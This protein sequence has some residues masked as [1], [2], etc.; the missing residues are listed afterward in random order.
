[1]SIVGK[2]RREIAWVLFFGVRYF[3]NAE[4]KRDPKP[5]YGEQESPMNHAFF[6]KFTALAALAL[7]IGCIKKDSGFCPEPN[8]DIQWV[9][10]T[11]SNG[12]WTQ[13]KCILCDASVAPEDYGTWANENAAEDTATHSISNEN[14]TPC[15]YV[16]PG[17]QRDW[18]TKAECIDAICTEEPNT[19]D[20][21][22]K[23]HGAWRVIK[24]ILGIPSSNMSEGTHQYMMIGTLKT[25]T[26][27]D[28]IRVEEKQV[29]SLVQ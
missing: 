20:G 19:N 6:F 16:Y 1:M 17:T 24:D 18:E 21:V 4:A 29:S 28:Q 15:L 14:A 11:E 23:N 22:H 13:T 27:F 10:Y 12:L 8:D 2:P 5:I 3:L 9:H 26:D 7:S 25:Q